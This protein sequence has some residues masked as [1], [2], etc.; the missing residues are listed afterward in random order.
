MRVTEKSSSNSAS[1][2]IVSTLLASSFQPHSTLR[3]MRSVPHSPPIAS[4]SASCVVAS[5]SKAG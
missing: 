1:R 2:S 4:M 5:A 3:I